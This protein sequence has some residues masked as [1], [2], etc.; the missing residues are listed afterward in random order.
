V[1]HG[2]F[3][4]HF[5]SRQIQA[6]LDSQPKWDPSSQLAIQT[7][8]YSALSHFLAKQ[9]VAAW[10]RSKPKPN[11]EALVE[12][13]SILREWNGQMEHGQA[14]PL[15]A[16]LLYQ[17]I[18]RG[19]VERA[20]PGKALM[21]DNRMGAAV[22]ETLLRERPGGWFPDYDQFLIASLAEAIDE[23]SRIQ[24]RDPSRWKYGQ[25]LNLRLAHPVLSRT[26][27]LGQ[28][29]TIGPV[30]MSGSATTVKQT[31]LRLGPSM[32]MVASA[33]D[34]DA[35]LQNLAIGQSG[36]P[37]SRHFKD[38][39]DEYYT[40]Q[41]LPMQFRKIDERSVLIFQPVH[42]ASQQTSTSSARNREVW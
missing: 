14:A 9:A 30:P 2:N 38:Q 41:S 36:Q 10:D 27:F 5:R 40:S 20:A 18:R 1:V 26:P 21:Y 42:P 35:S 39:W 22:V 19:I 32:R 28:Y 34:W 12:P 16:T 33:A 3:D 29:F 8:V 15:V 11:K 23:G 4:S 7:D 31:T 37:L 6:R 25:F 13:I 17:H 24:G